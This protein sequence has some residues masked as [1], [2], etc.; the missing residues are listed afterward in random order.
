MDGAAERG[1]LNSNSTGGESEEVEVAGGGDS[2]AV[3]LTHSR[4][5]RAREADCGSG[6]DGG[7]CGTAFAREGGAADRERQEEEELEEEV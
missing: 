6:G 4:V 1:T 5:R 2:G 3:I 7:C